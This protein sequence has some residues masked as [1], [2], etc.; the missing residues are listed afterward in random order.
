MVY[1]SFCLPLSATL[2]ALG[3]LEGPWLSQS[4]IPLTPELL[5][6]A[7]PSFSWFPSPTSVPY[8]PLWFSFWKSECPVIWVSYSPRSF[9]SI[10]SVPSSFQPTS[11]GKPTCFAPVFCVNNTSWGIGTPPTFMASRV[12]VGVLGEGPISEGLYFSMWEEARGGMAG[13]KLNG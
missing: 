8:S 6:S 9:G 7:V 12:G 3:C 5:E 13:Q 10:S 1:V 4:H 2:D 11:D